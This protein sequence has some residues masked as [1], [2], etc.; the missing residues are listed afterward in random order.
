MT[1]N[2]VKKIRESLAE[3]QTQFAARLGYSRYQTVLEL[4]RW[5]KRNIPQEAA[6]RIRVLK[7][8]K[9]LNGG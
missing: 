2:D 5:G 9:R 3:T 8:D 7:L 4:E 1:G 6:W